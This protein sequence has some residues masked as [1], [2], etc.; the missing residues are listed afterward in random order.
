MRHGTIRAVGLVG[1]GCAAACLAVPG[2]AAGAGQAARL[3]NARLDD[4]DASYATMT[5]T[6]CSAGPCRA[7]P[8]VIKVAD[9]GLRA[10][11]R[12]FRTGDHLALDVDDKDELRSVGIHAVPVGRTERVVAL[13]VCALLI[14]LAAALATRFHPLALVLGDDGRY[15]KS[16]IQMA[17]W[18]LVLMATYLAAVS[19]R[20]AHAGW[21]FL[22]RV[23]IPRNLVLL[24]GMSALTFGGAK[25]ITSNKVR[26][27][28]AARQPDPKPEGR[29]SVWNLVQNDVG[30]FDLGDFQMMVVT[31]LAVAMYLVLTFRFLGSIEFRASVALPDLD[32]TILA[33]FGLGQGA[34]LVK[35]AAGEPGTT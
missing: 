4:L 20:V 26:T 1:L 6:D 27:A 35:K 34:Y 8:R 22:G 14:L 10:E 9:S 21:E 30:A 23:D 33:T 29:A 24:S 11:L 31:G 28:L 32:T 19:L 13:A 17:I 12:S 15:S 2:W 18:F 16:K 3:E 7:P 5:V 25:G